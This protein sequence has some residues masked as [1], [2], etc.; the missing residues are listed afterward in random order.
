[1]ALQ[2]GIKSHDFWVLAGIFSVCG[3]STNGL[4]GQ[5]ASDSEKVTT[6]C[7]ALSLGVMACDQV[8]YADSVN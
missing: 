1:M 2:D 8:L 5:R 3:A 6:A 4:I 7:C